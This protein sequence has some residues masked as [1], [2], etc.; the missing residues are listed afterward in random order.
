LELRLGN[1]DGAA[2]DMEVMDAREGDSMRHPGN[3]REEA[4]KVRELGE[5]EYMRQAK[6]EAVEWIS[7]HP[8]EFLRLTASRVIHF[9]FGPLHQPLM[10]AAISLLTILALLGA[11]RTLPALT[12]PQRAALLIPLV[13]FP[14]VYYIVTYMSRYAVPIN[15]LL[16]MFAGA[17][18]WHWIKRSAIYSEN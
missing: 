18:V 14:L 8:S 11:R 6:R 4:F 2:A 17:E 5:M 9:W 7:A 10:A 12:M 16:L 1:H 3:N 15:W 13:T